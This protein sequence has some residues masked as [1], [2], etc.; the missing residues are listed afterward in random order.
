M[1]SATPSRP[2]LTRN[3]LFHDPDYPSME[4]LSATQ[5]AMIADL[6][7]RIATG[8]I[9]YRPIP[10]LCGETEARN[11]ATLDRYRIRQDTVICCAC[12]LLRSDPL[13]DD[14]ALEWFYSSD[15]YR[16]LY[17]G[18]DF[19]PHTAEKFS[20][21]L[22]TADKRFDIIGAILPGRSFTRVAEIGCGAGW[23][24]HPFFRR[25][26]SVVGCDYSPELTAFGRSMGMDIRTG[27]IEQLR[28]GKCD[29]V[30]MSHVLEHMPDPEAMIRAIDGILAENGSLYIEVPDLRDFCIGTL[31]SAHVWT[32]APVHLAALLGKCGFRAISVVKQGCHF[33]A[34][35]ERSPAKWSGPAG[36]YAE[37]AAMITRHDRRQS[38]K[39]LLDS[40]GLL[41]LA[42][43]VARL[44]RRG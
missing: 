16:K 34:V 12:G 35:F 36:N 14:A 23:N 2:R 11:V 30:I 20:G 3:R 41:A 40:L 37:F 8:R 1:S 28:D 42:K 7:D 22:P 32:F 24:L 10:C 31:Q 5:K 4:D 18:E 38:F 43:G 9:G 6:N 19:I 33:A 17:S 26:I 13:M 21:M 25:G 27:S 39:D 44:L 15:F 29:L